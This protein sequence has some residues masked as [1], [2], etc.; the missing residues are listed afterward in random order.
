MALKF[1]LLFEDNFTTDSPIDPIGAPNWNDS[2]DSNFGNLQVG[3]D[4]P[5]GENVGELS[6]TSFN[7][8]YEAGQQFWSGNSPNDCYVQYTL[9]TPPPF[10]E[11]AICS[12]RSLANTAKNTGYYC[13]LTD[14]EIIVKK[15]RAGSTIKTVTGLTVSS[16]DTFIFAVVASTH[17]IFQNGAQISTFIDATYTTGGAGTVGLGTVITNGNTDVQYTDFQTGSA[18]ISSGGGQGNSP[19]GNVIFDLDSDGFPIAELQTGTN[20]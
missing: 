1:T 6:L 17:Y 13:E 19:Q 9:A 7:D 15:G 5:G 11:G 2:T 10:S 14:G 16:G 4:G 3:N 20:S 8:G 12:Y 18:S